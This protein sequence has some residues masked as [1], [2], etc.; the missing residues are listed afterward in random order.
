MAPLLMVM[1]P[2]GGKRSGHLSPSPA[3]PHTSAAALAGA[4]EHRGAAPLR[5]K[6]RL[7]PNIHKTRFLLFAPQT[8]SSQLTSSS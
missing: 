6:K 1:A 5:S 4:G 8:R 2:Q 3:L 7:A